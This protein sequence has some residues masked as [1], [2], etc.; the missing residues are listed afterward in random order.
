MTA[1]PLWVIADDGTTVILN[2]TLTQQEID[3][4]LAQMR[5]ANIG[6]L[7]K[8]A[9]AYESARI[10]GSALATL[11]IGVGKDLPK[12]IA[13]QIWLK[14]IWDLYY[15][16]IDSVT[17]KFDSINTDFS[18]CGEIPYPINELMAEVMSPDEVTR[19][20]AIAVSAATLAP[21]KVG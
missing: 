13:V 20:T 15:S 17:Y 6:N 7:R 12:S 21:I 2:P 11:A 9:Y 19:M 16:R 1:Q 8:A 4:R 18:E 5:E 3:D 14:S 10:S